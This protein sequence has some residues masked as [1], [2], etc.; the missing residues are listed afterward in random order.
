MEKMEV[1][2]PFEGRQNHHVVDGFG[3]LTFLY[4][5]TFLGRHS[6]LSWK[7]LAWAESSIQVMQVC[8]VCHS[9]TSDE[10]PVAYISC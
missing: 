8:Q 1:K 10:F 3:F 9:F 7:K 4:V 5:H 6:Q 2:E